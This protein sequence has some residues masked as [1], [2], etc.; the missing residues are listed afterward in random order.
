MQ[1]MTFAE[2]RVKWSVILKDRFSS[3][4]F[5]QRARI[6][7]KLPGWLPDFNA[8][9]TGKLPMFLSRLNEKSGGIG[10]LCLVSG[11]LWRILKFF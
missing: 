6:H 2:M 11:S 4:I 1:W 3:G 7:L 8:L 10:N 9:L 5:L